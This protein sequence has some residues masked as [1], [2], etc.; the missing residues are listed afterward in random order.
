MAR[1]ETYEPG[2]VGEGQH[3]WAPDAPGAG[4]AK[5]RTVRGHKK[6]YEGNETQEAAR[7]EPNDNPDFP[8]EGV[9]ES[10]SRRGEQV[11]KGNEPGRYDAGTKGKSQRPVGKSSPEDSS[12]VGAQKPID[13]S[14]PNMPAGDQG[15]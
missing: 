9:G 10:K 11:K 3:G 1:D 7:G 14:M 15:G 13:E 2:K 6:A 12:G 5:Q 8:P 4:D